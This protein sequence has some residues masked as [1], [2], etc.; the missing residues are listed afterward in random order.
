MPGDRVGSYEVVGRLGAGGMG[1]VYRARDTRLGRDVALKV[2]RSGADPELLRRLD[3][4]ARSASALN[5]PNIVHIYDP[6]CRFP[7]PAA[8]RSQ[9]RPAAGEPRLHPFSGAIRL[10]LAQSPPERPFGA[11]RSS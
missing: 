5:H 10:D 3:R 7:D 1:E 2:L 9:G 6:L 8:G 11:P 4:E